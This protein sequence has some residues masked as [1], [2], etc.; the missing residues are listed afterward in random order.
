MAGDPQKVRR[1]LQFR[2][3]VPG[4]NPEHIVA[5]LRAAKPYYE[6]FGAGRPRLLQNV[7]DPSR[8][9]QEIEYELHE[10]I[11]LNRQRVAS[12]ARVQAYLQTWRSLLPDGVQIDVFREV[13]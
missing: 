1:T 7:D 4:A 13:E 3:T 6:V 11:E 8:F 12:D 9:V 5:M 10:F 2:F